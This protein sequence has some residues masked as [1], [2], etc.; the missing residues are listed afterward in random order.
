MTGRS[1][2][3]ATLQAGRLVLR[4]F[5]PGDAA[6]VHAVWNDQAYL[7]FAPA[8]F[9]YAAASL[10]Q[11]AEWC[12]HGAD[13]QRRAGQGVSFAGAPPDG[14]RLVCQVALF[15]TD[16]TAMITEIHYW[17]APW[18]RGNGYAAEAARAVACW[19]LTEQSFARVTLKTV[20]DNAASRAVAQAAGF[21]FEGIMRNAAWTRAGRGD[22]AIYSL[23]PDDLEQGQ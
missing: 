4:P 7:R 2:P 19:A 13:G 9:R 5:R 15:G 12:A 3:Q 14:A 20:T 17:T 22:M 11:A 23:I 16:W 1:F 6:D 18:A 10:D 21:R 8:G